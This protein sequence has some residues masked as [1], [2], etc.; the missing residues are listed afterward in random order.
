MV[1][2]APLDLVISRQLNLMKFALDKYSPWL[3][4]WLFDY[5]F[6]GVTKKA[7][8][9]LDPAWRLS[10]AP[11]LANHQPVISDTLVNNLRENKITSVYGIKRF[12]GE[13]ELELEDGT[14]LEVDTVIWTTGYESNFSIFRDYDPFAPVS[15][16]STTNIK[17][18]QTM[19]PD[20]LRLA[21]LYQ[22]I[23][24]PNYASSLAFMN[25]AALTDGAMTLVDVVAMAIAQIWKPSNPYALPSPTEMAQHI[26]DHHTWVRSLTRNGTESVY[27]GVVRPG[28]FYRFL[29]EAAGTGL[30]D[31]LRFTIKGFKLWLKDRKLY[32]LMMWGVMTP[33]M[34]RI[35]DV[36]G[37]EGRKTW[38]GARDAILHANE[39]AKIYKS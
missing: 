8:P 16:V 33:Y 2:G 25:Y 3:S 5:V 26:A 28:N 36:E 11:S 19:A 32:Q 15:A 1:D 14:K 37:R 29:N 21:S 27:A 30:D 31:Y 18:K 35:F 39:L 23:F 7:F 17:A 6:E 13:K 12:L 24:P 9:N 10:P 34:Y 22:N 20:E 4:K 38:D